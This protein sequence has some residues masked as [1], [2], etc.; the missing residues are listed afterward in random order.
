[1]NAEIGAGATMNTSSRRHA[2]KPYM[3]IHFL[4]ISI[5]TSSTD[6][7]TRTAS[8]FFDY[9]AV[10]FGAGAAKPLGIV[11]H[12]DGTCLSC[13]AQPEENEGGHEDAAF[14]VLGSVA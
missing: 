4:G 7:I 8:N 11:F 6:L 5:L 14:V 13:R 12:H 3:F 2:C 10:Y 1:V 9:I